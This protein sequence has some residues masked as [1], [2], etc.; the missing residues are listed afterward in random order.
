MILSDTFADQHLKPVLVPRRGLEPPRLAPLVPETS[1]STNSATWAC[2]RHG[3]FRLSAPDRAV[4][5]LRRR[6]AHL[7]SRPQAALHRAAGFD[8]ESC[9]PGG[10]ESFHG[11]L[12]APAF[13]ATCDRVRRL[14]VLG[15]LRGPGA[16]KAQLPGPRGGAPAE[17]RRERA[18]D[19]RG[20]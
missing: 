9:V 18:A 3:V 13:A 17:P 19:R 12:L 8:Y 14:G 15:P 20:R 11:R 6:V 16:D 7:A 4:N 1:A 5:R 2:Q 10:Q